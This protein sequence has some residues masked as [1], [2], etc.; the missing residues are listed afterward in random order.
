MTDQQ[1]GPGQEVLFLSAYL[2]A[3]FLSPKEE[4][5][6]ALAIVQHLF[7]REKPRWTQRR[8]A[9]ALNVSEKTVKRWLDRKRKT[10]LRPLARM[11]IFE[12]AQN[13]RL[14][15]GA[16]IRREQTL[17]VLA[18][19]LRDRAVDQGLARNL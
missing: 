1:K 9:G 2:C 13:L 16:I 7:T 19:A 8:I 11:S 4:I 3:R 5:T 6:L 17:N 12:L 14:D 18:L 15:I 10:E